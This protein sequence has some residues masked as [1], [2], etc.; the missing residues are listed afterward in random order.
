MNSETKRARASLVLAIERLGQARIDDSWSGGG[1]PA[2]IPHIEQKLR[3]AQTS[4]QLKLD[5][6]EEAIRHDERTK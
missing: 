6:Y 1:N 4:L 5:I 2:D 3:N